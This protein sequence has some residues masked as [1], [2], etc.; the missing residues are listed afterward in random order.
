[1]SLT[2]FPCKQPSTC[3]SFWGS[4]EAL[5]ATASI[6]T[7][8]CYEARNAVPKPVAGPSAREQRRSQFPPPNNDRKNI[9]PLPIEM[10]GMAMELQQSASLTN[11]QFRPHRWIALLILLGCAIGWLMVLIPFRHLLA[12]FVL[13]QLHQTLGIIIFVL[14]LGRVFLRFTHPRPY[15]Q[16]PISPW[17]RRTLST[18]QASIFVLLAAIPIFGYL[19]AATAP[20]QIP[21]FFLGFIQVPNLVGKALAWFPILR[22]LHRAFA[23]LL[24]FLGFGEALAAIYWTRRTR[25]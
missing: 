2:G 14:F 10:T 15:S 25:R 18:L 1:M 20:G 19:T 11:G 13:Y 16:Q 22:H 9:G 17:Q 3:Q 6:E 23:N 21:I 4:A 24:V 8:G 12:K 7:Q 5:E